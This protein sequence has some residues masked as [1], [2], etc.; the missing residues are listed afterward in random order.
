MEDGDSG[1]LDEKK[2]CPTKNKTNPLGSDRPSHGE[3]TIPMPVAVDFLSQDP[4]PQL[5]QL[6]SSA[7]HG[8]LFR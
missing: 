7:F 1:K 5:H 2:S 3:I 6:K 4:T 8:A